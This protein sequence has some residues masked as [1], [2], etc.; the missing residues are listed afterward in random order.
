MRAYSSAFFFISSTLKK[1]EHWAGCYAN[2]YAHFGNRSTYRV[3][4]THTAID[5][6]GK[7]FFR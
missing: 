5:Y 6:I 3:E 1:R 4:G 7:G 2:R